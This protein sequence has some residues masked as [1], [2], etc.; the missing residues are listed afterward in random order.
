MDLQTRDGCL[1]SRDLSDTPGLAT[2]ISETGGVDE[3]LCRDGHDI[4]C[5]GSAFAEIGVRRGIWRQRRQVS[6]A[7]KMYND[8]TTHVQGTERYTNRT[9]Q[10]G[11]RSNLGE[12]TLAQ[13]H[14]RDSEVR[15]ITDCASTRTRG[16][17]GGTGA[18]GADGQSLIGHC[19]GRRQR[20]Y[21]G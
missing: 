20:K 10:H 21:D 19:D 2:I 7:K 3:K 1:E 15:S 13:S 5:R 6:V 14:T 16:P 4:G 11:G 9:G 12:S 18:G 8:R 17:E